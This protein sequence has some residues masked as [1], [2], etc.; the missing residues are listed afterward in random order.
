MNALHVMNALN[1][2]NALKALNALNALNTLN[3]LAQK[4]R[5]LEHLLL[6]R[7]QYVVIDR[8]AQWLTLFT[9]IKLSQGGCH[10]KIWQ[11]MNS[12][13]ARS[14]YELIC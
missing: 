1:A 13:C 6:R 11:Y 3:A 9:A 14:R 7:Q 8:N 10:V 5:T 12:E 4:P 2:L